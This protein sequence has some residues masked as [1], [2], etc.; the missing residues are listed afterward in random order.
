MAQC[1]LDLSHPSFELAS[2]TFKA[3]PAFE[4]GLKELKRKVEAEHTSC[5]RVVQPMPGYPDCQNK[6]WKYDW[7]PTGD[8]SAGRK[9][10]RMVVVVPE[11]NIQPYRLIAI[12]VYA[13]N[14]TS[15]LSLKALA[16]IFATATSPYPD[17]TKPAETEKFRRVNQPDGQ[18]RSLCLNCG[19]TVAV[20][21]EELNI[22]DGEKQ[23]SC[24]GQLDL[25]AA[26]T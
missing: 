17:A 23:H 13:K 19:E 12:S 7:A 11:P 9:S 26:K 16:K 22:E 2:A 24:D 1:T 21:L 25:W 10:W 15:Q 5:N 18:T 14:Q 6:I 4:G 3:D 8:R 20:A